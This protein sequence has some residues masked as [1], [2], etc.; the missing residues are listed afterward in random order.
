MAAPKSNTREKT[1]SMSREPLESVHGSTSAFWADCKQG[2]MKVSRPQ[3]QL[4]VD[5]LRAAPYCE[6]ARI[7]SNLSFYLRPK[8]SLGL[9]DSN[10]AMISRNLPEQ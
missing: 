6:E 5:I 8:K 4:K 3:T 9:H 7:G 1:V 2:N 10:P